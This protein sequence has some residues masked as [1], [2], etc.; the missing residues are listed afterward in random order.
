MYLTKCFTMAFDIFAAAR[1]RLLPA[2]FRFALVPSRP[3]WR[4]AGDQVG[5]THRVLLVG[6]VAGRALA[7]L[8]DTCTEVTDRAV[9]L[10]MEREIVTGAGFDHVVLRTANLSEPQHPLHVYLD[11]DGTPWLGGQPATDPTPDWLTLTNRDG[12]PRLLDPNDPVRLDLLASFPHK[13][14]IFPVLVS[15]SID[16]NGDATAGRIAIIGDRQCY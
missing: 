13:K 6:A 14:P 16:A 10:G 7:R 12:A 9:A 15:L 5:A 11:H 1:S 8:P 2:A 3:A 4:A